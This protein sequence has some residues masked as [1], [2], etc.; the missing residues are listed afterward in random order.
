V[1]AVFM[2]I[3]ALFGERRHVIVMRHDGAFLKA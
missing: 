1:A 3:A 2:A